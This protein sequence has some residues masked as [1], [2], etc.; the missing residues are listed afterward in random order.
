MKTFLMLL[1]LCL[2]LIPLKSLAQHVS[3]QDS[4]LNHLSGK[5]ILD[6]TIAGNQTTHDVLSEWILGNQYLQ[7]TEVSREKDL[8]GNPSYDA[9]VFITWNKSSNLFDCLWLDNTGNEGLRDGAVGHSEF[10]KDRLEFIFNAADGSIFHTTFIYDKK[11]D[12][13]QWLMD[14]EENNKIQPFARLTLMR[15]NQ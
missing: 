15:S 3:G 10:R 6:G 4:L 1:T 2:Q 7:L 13:W 5:W 9:K 8:K 12:M 11:T 14:G